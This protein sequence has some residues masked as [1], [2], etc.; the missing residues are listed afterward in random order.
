[1]VTFMFWLLYPLIRVPWYP[2]DMKLGGSTA[3]LDMLVKKILL[4]PVITPYS[5][6]L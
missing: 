2:L 3:S 5:S 6:S 4:L 1:M